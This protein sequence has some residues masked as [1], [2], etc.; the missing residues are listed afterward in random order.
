MPIIQPGERLP[1]GAKVVASKAIGNTVI[2]LCTDFHGAHEYV[3][4]ECLLDEPKGTY[5]GHYITEIWDAA[6]DYKERID[7]LTH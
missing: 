6:N 5:G 3:T 4:W 1:N 7:K 2:Y